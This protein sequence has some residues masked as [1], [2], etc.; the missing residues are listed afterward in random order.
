MTI[1]ITNGIYYI[2]TNKNDAIIKT[3]ILEAAQHFYNVNVASRKMQKA[4][5]KCKSYYVFD[6]DGDDKP[7]TG[8]KILR[9][10]K[11]VKYNEDV[12]KML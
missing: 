5:G 2:A 8:K 7:E 4:P 11:R 12:L 1:V 10:K 3:P 9:K 6:T